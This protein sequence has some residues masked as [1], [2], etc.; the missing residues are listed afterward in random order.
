MNR[1]FLLILVSIFTVSTASAQTTFLKKL[2]KGEKQTVVFYGASAAINTSNRVWVDQLR[3]RL[4]RRFPE[5]I[6]FY[7]CSKSGIGSFWATENFKDSVLSRKSDLLIFGFSE[8]DAVTRFNNAP[9]YSG[10]CA[11]YMVLYILSE[12]PLGQSAETRPELAAFNASCRE[13]AKKKGIILVDYSVEFNK[14]YD[15]G[16]EEALKPYQRD[17]ILPTRK[18][19]Q[20]ILVPMLW[21]AILGRDNAKK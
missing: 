4:E 21:D 5:K 14:I 19:A 7:N 18:A 20:E 2:K 10:K 8:N 3:T 12:R 6:T 16:G 9:W 15:A 17:G 11:E 1:I 13:A